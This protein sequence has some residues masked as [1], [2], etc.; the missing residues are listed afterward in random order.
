MITLKLKNKDRRAKDAL[1][2]AVNRILSRQ[3]TDDSVLH[4]LGHQV[5]LFNKELIDVDQF[6]ATM[7][8]I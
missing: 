7:S 3:D 1:D 8:A 2:K 6:I 4:N 5:E